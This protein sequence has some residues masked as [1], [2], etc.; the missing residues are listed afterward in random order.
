[1]NKG[2]NKK[3]TTII[4]IYVKFSNTE[5]IRLLFKYEVLT[6]TTCNPYQS[7]GIVELINRFNRMNKT[8]TNIILSFVSNLIK[9]N[10]ERIDKILQRLHVLYFKKFRCV[11][12]AV[13]YWSNRMDSRTD[14]TTNIGAMYFY[15]NVYNS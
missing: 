15:N 10:L 1:M 3:F 11:F 5:K 8:F 9:F 4:Y 7:C 12:F 6:K 2:L 14:Q 13:L